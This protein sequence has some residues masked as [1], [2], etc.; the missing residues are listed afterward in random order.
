M[1]IIRYICKI[2]SEQLKKKFFNCTYIEINKYITKFFFETIIGKIIQHPMYNNIISPLQVKDKMQ[3]NL[4][5]FFRFLLMIIKEEVNT[6]KHSFQHWYN[7]EE[8]MYD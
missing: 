2:I 1:L 4:Y 8:V 6:D 5:S 3:S 7:D